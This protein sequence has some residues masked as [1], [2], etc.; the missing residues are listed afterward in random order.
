MKRLLGILYGCVLVMLC[1]QAGAIA[2]N[3]NATC[4][5]GVNSNGVLEGRLHGGFDNS[6]IYWVAQEMGLVGPNGEFPHADP[7][8]PNRLVYTNNNG[9]V[10][11]VGTIHGPPGDRYWVT[12]NKD[13]LYDLAGWDGPK[14]AWESVWAGNANQQGKLILVA[15]GTPGY[16]Q[17]GDEVPLENVN[18]TGI[19]LGGA[20]Y[21][22]FQNDD[23]TNDNGT[24]LSIECGSQFGPFPL[25][26]RPNAN[27]TVFLNSCLSAFDPPGDDRKSVI[28][29]ME[30]VE[31]VNS[32]SGYTGYTHK[33]MAIAANGNAAAM[34]LAYKA[35]AKKALQL[36]YKY[37]KITPPGQP[38]EYEGHPGM[39]ANQLKAKDVRNI[40]QQAVDDAGV[41]GLTIT[42]RV[43]KDPQDDDDEQAFNWDYYLP[44]FVMYPGSESRAIYHPGAD[45]IPVLVTLDATQ[46]TGCE[47][48]EFGPVG[49]LSNLPPGLMTIATP[50][51][52][53]AFNQNFTLPVEMTFQV[54]PGSVLTGIADVTDG[55]WE[56][57]TPTF[58]P[59]GLSTWTTSGR[60]VVPVAVDTSCPS[61][62][63]DTGSTDVDD[64]LMLLAVYGNG[65]PEAILLGDLDGDFMVGVNDLLVLLDGWGVCY[66]PEEAGACCTESTCWLTMPD[67]C[68]DA[69][70]DWQGEGSRCESADCT[71]GEQDGAC[72]YV[73]GD[74]SI[75]CLITLVTECQT[76]GRPYL[77]LECDK[78]D[79]PDSFG[80]CC[81]QEG[82]T[83]TCIN[84]RTPQECTQAG[85]EYQG[86]DT[87][88][89]DDPCPVNTSCCLDGNML[90]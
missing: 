27:I 17:P 86:H 4:V 6:A 50:M 13:R 70:G 5:Y 3:T 90:R 28:D 47:A 79:C 16:G 72:C 51:S 55:G 66:W 7:N 23:G 31:G 89:E 62:L 20:P 35:M 84:G 65:L 57:T 76:F 26:P 45:N 67:L 49:L 42:L 11:Q 69:A 71:Y 38:V 12:N 36:G 58:K 60:S 61:D 83:W 2:A 56:M 85:G 30:T 24:G 1:L 81:I 9:S 53:R 43:T 46:A 87:W 82:T 32:A 52:L 25:K 41:T 54:P 8:D 29:T 14:H 59:E 80:A 10:V 68:T 22:G 88:C 63:N 64:L 78:V 48:F 15:H 19:I 34:P 33:K 21:G 37:P 75:K 73:D 44:P 18:V 39:M 40:L 77:G 74:G